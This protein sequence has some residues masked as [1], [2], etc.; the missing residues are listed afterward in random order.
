M[1][2]AS[3]ISTISYQILF[4]N[5]F[6]VLF[7]GYDK[8]MR[9]EQWLENR[10]EY[11]FRNY[12]ADVEATNQIEI[13]WGRRSRRQLGCIKKE[14]PKTLADRFKRDFI[15]IIVINGLFRDEVIPEFIIDS[16]IVHEMAHYAHGFNSPIE[17]KYRHPHKGNVIR[18][19]FLLRGIGDL[20]KL[21]KKWMKENWQKYL[22]DNFPQSRKIHKRRVKLFFR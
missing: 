13:M 19:E 21:Q 10:F 18:R 3:I 12:F 14:Q 16:V 9:N 1:A 11:I 15:T 6:L 5:V 20:E 4:V 8:I 22:D 17:Q 7:F 2:V